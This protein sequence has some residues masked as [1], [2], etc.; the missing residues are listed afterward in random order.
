MGRQTAAVWRERD[1]WGARVEWG[2]SRAAVTW[3]VPQAVGNNLN[4]HG[5]VW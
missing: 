5:V 1:L 3:T 2:H 4:A